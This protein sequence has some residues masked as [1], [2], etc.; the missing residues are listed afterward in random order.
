MCGIWRKSRL[1]VK[2]SQS[3]DDGGNIKSRRRIR[4]KRESSP[5]TNITSIK[6][7][8]LTFTSHLLIQINTVQRIE[9]SIHLKL[10]DWQSYQKDPK[11]NNASAFDV[12]PKL[13]PLNNAASLLRPK[14]FLS[15]ISSS[16]AIGRLQENQHL[17]IQSGRT[18]IRLVKRF[19]F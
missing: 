5:Y 14:F 4:K 18:A 6:I 10:L 9:Y 7:N 1:P 16:R 13:P 19:E 2:S 15:I 17:S 8:W 11:Q 12:H 3:T